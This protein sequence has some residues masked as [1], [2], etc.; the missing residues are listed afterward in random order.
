[1]SLLSQQVIG[2]LLSAAI[3]LPPTLLSNTS[4][5]LSRAVPSA[6]WHHLFV[7][8]EARGRVLEPSFPC[9]EPGLLRER[10]DSQR[11][12]RPEVTGFLK[13]VNF[14]LRTSVSLLLLGTPEANHSEGV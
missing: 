1:M 13:A 10:A 6:L 7:V 11:S 2:T 5:G 14:V 4:P 3:L 9:G 8:L 12:H